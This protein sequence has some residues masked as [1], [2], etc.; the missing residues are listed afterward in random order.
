MKKMMMNFIRDEGFLDWMNQYTQS[1]SNS[2]LKYGELDLCCKEM[3]DTTH[4]N[5]Q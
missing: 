4:N 2:S 3:K 1:I 5:N